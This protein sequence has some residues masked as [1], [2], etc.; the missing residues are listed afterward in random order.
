MN[1]RTISSRRSGFTLIELLVVIAI[2][3]V[4]AGMIAPAVVS[5][6]KK[7]KKAKAQTEVSSIAQAITSY[8]ADYS[9]LPA[10]K[11]TRDAHAAKPAYNNQLATVATPDWVFGNFKTVDPKGFEPAAVVASLT[12]YQEVVDPQ[13]GGRNP[14]NSEVMAIL[15]G[16]TLPDVVAGNSDPVNANNNQNPKR[17]I[18][19]NAKV[20]P[21]RQANGIDDLGV[22]RDPWGH[23]F[24]I[25]LD[26]DYDSRVLS[27]FPLIRAGQPPQPRF[28]PGSVL[29]MSLGPDGKA[30]FTVDQDHPNNRDNIYSWK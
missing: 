30:D 25:I 6:V 14:N 2:I 7:A 27:P 17:N 26:L 1:T 21:T 9:R 10:T 3:G 11:R 22:Y 15:T 8:Q 12:G 29:V 19:L 28:I 24:I 18:Y 16:Q 23:P 20:V 13:S 4:L 5:A